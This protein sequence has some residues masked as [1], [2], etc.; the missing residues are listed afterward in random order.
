MSFLKGFRARWRANVDVRRVD[1]DLSEEIRF[2]ID[3]E[4]EKNVALGHAPVDIAVHLSSAVHTYV[5]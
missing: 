4:T 1:D 3:R 2:H 5:P